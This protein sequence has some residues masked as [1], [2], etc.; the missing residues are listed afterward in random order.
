MGLFD[1]LFKKKEEPK[2]EYG[3]IPTVSLDEKHAARAYKEVFF[4]ASADIYG[5]NQK[6]IDEIV[7]FVNKVTY[8]NLAG[9]WET[10]FNTYFYGRE[11]G[12]FEIKYWLDRLSRDGVEPPVRMPKYY[13]IPSPDSVN[14]FDN[15]DFMQ[16]VTI[17]EMKKILYGLEV[18]Y[19]SSAKKSDLFTLMMKHQS[20]EI[21][22]L[23]KIKFHKY[24]KKKN[25]KLYECLMYT[26]S[27]RAHSLMD[28]QRMEKIGVKHDI[29]IFLPE[30]KKLMPYMEEYLE[31]HPDAVLPIIPGCA[32]RYKP[33]L[34]DYLQRNN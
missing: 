30:D 32:D 17:P 21:D 15:N 25:K 6:E 12:W 5:I 29:D 34:P 14:L 9:Y 3:A 7:R 33:V 23:K 19:K 20:K 11:W 24:V 8:I 31:Q 2:P 18:K 22:D 4:R 27:F 16:S 13:H 10:V 26:M 28:L 1:F